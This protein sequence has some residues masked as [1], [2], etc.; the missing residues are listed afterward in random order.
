M[1]DNPIVQ[2]NIEIVR[3]YNTLIQTSKIESS[4]KHRLLSMGIHL[5]S[6]PDMHL[7]KQSRWLGFIQGVLFSNNL[8]D[9]NEE[10]DITRPLFHSAYRELDMKI[11]ETVDLTI[12]SEE[13]LLVSCYKDLYD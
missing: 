12:A 6:N 7:D 10:R 5:I 4:L 13:E 1:Q 8:L 9:I 3:R 11:P 2:A